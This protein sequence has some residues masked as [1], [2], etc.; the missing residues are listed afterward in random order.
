[1]HLPRYS[2]P[3]EGTAYTHMDIGLQLFTG[4]AIIITRSYQYYF[5]II[6]YCA[7]NETIKKYL[8]SLKILFLFFLLLI[9]ELLVPLTRIQE[10]V[11]H[12]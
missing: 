12:F 3:G 6:L 11:L 4:F 5:I 7:P 1:M 10:S 9:I 2:C 8:F